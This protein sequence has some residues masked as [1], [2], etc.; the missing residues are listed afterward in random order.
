MCQTLRTHSDGKVE[1]NLSSEHL[2]PVISV[3]PAIAQ[4]AQW[5][6]IRQ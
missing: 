6:H 5:L 2:F 1:H 3:L 4:G